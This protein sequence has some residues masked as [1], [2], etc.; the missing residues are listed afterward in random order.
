[1]IT[2]FLAFCYVFILA[3]SY[4][5]ALSVCSERILGYRFRYFTSFLWAGV[6]FFSVYVQVFSL[7]SG[8]GLVA[9]VV[10][11]VGCG[12]FD[13]LLRRSLKE[14]IREFFSLNKVIGIVTLGL[15]FSYGASRGYSHYD[16]AL[17]HAQAIRWIEEYGVVKGLGLLH[18]RLAYNSAS[19]AISA[20]FSFSFFDN[21]EPMHAMAGFFTYLLSLELLDWKKIFTEKKIN[22]SDVFCVGIFYYLTLAYNEIVSPA[23]DF[24]AMSAVFFLINLWIKLFENKENNSV[25]YAWLCVFGV[26]ACTIKFSACAIVLLT[27]FPAI[28]FIREKKVKEIFFFCGSGMM[29][30]L[31]FF[32]RNVIISGR[33]LYPSTVLDIFNVEW[34]IPE[35]A[36]NADRMEIIG[37]GRGINSIEGY[38]ASFGDWFPTY[39]SGQSIMV[40]IMFIL[41]ALGLAFGIVFSIYYFVRKRKENYQWSF[42][43]LVVYI[44]FF[45]W[46]FSAPLVRYG[47]VYLICPFVIIFG[48]LTIKIKRKLIQKIMVFLCIVFI[49]WKTF[50]LGKYAFSVRK[51]DYYV[52]QQPYEQFDVQAVKIKDEIIYIPK[53]GDRTGY[54]YFPSTPNLNCE[55]RGDSLKEGFVRRMQNDSKN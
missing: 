22:L 8:V 53:E 43:S 15:L 34:K 52:F 2:V 32:I 46:L 3:F 51:S 27:L 45:T 44:C 1:M 4:G 42:I 55:L 37:W 13:I 19:F 12:F 35:A 18:N 9:N 39:F 50:E 30:A 47:Y 7:F 10:L 24:F 41:D 26:Y 5:N 38:Y 29:V 48:Y 54:Y 40:K 31:P 16:T 20:L 49:G 17:Y 23:S 14:R 33:L 11:V 36:A 28:K 21:L 25:P 6:V